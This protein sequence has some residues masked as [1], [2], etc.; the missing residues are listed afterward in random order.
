MDIIRAVTIIPVISL[1]ACQN[2]QAPTMKSPPTTVVQPYAELGADIAK[3]HCAAC[4]NVSPSGDSPRS[5]APP[6]RIVLSQYNPEALADDFREH[7]HVGHP[8]MPDFD[9]TVKETEGLLSYLRMIQETPAK[10]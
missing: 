4:H 7:I 9:F 1:V 8:D 2:V 6:L 10:D 5:D 3:T